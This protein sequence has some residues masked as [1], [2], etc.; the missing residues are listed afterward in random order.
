MPITPLLVHTVLATIFTAPR[1]VQPRRIGR[2]RATG[3]ATAATAPP[4]LANHAR[5]PPPPHVP[6]AIVP[7]ASGARQRNDP[8]AHNRDRGKAF[9]SNGP[10]VPAARLASA[11]PGPWHWSWPRT[12]RLARQPAPA[13]QQCPWC[14]EM[15]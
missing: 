12:M 6:A 1:M 13:R 2:Q 3:R 7:P 11:A 15:G 4:S 5:L 10:D 9:P 14:Q 8:A